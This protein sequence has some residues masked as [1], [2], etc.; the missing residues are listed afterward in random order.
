MRRSTFVVAVFCIASSAFAQTSPPLTQATAPNNSA[1]MTPLF[2]AQL[3]DALERQYQKCWNYTGATSGPHYIPRIRVEF[4]PGGALATL[5]TLLNPPSDL[6]LR[7]LANGALRAIQ[8]C[9][10]LKIPEQFAPYYGQWRLR[11]L[12]FD[13]ADFR[14]SAIPPIAQK[15]ITTDN[16]S[17]L[18]AP[19]PLIDIA[20]Q[21]IFPMLIIVAGIMLGALYIW[22]RN[23]ESIKASTEQGRRKERESKREQSEVK[24]SSMNT[25]QALDILGLKTGATEQ[26]IRA[27]FSRLMKRV[28]PDAGG[29]EFLAKQLN[30]A[31]DFLLG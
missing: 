11:V 13:P 3:D 6:A 16:A 30:A 4:T 20:P 23:L 2:W 19:R 17:V 25:D 24:W 9:N 12:Q 18:N 7:D 1:K 5:P 28:H 8:R 22:R 15:P 31:R 29:S 14:S 21:R 26:E 27:A 10:P